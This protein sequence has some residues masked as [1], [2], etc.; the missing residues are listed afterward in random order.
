MVPSGERSSK[1]RSFTKA[2]VDIVAA[3][4]SVHTSVA[5]SV[6][7]PPPPSATEGGEKETHTAKRW[8]SERGVSASKRATCG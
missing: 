2:C 1:S 7:P 6:L 4:G 8:F 3:G 5:R